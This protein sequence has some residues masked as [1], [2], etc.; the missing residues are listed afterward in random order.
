M[1]KRLFIIH[2]WGGSP[3]EILLQLLKDKFSKEGF[4]THIPEM[5]DTDNPKINLW[6]NKLKEIVKNPDKDTYFIGHSIGSQAVLRYLETLYNKVGKVIL[7]APWMH[8]DKNTIEEEGE[9][10]A[11][12]AKPWMETPINWKRIKGVTNNFLCVFSDNDPY[13][14]LS[15]KELFRKELGAKVITERNMGHFI[16]EIGKERLSEFVKKLIF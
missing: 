14:P 2:G 3:K 12:I 16:N 1:V 4:E 7:I 10:T 11:E 9:E 5:P 8:L 13:V 15:E 6:I